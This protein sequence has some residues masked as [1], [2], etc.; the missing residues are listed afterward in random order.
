[1]PG[2][3]HVGCY[4]FP[5]YH[6]DPRNE[7]VHGKGWTEWEVVKR[8]CPRFAGHEQPR[9]PR[10]GYEDEAD[11]RVMARKI[12]AAADH[13]VDGFIFD[14][15]WYDDGPFLNR[16]LERGFLRAPNRERLRFSCMWANHDWTDIHPAGRRQPYTLLYPGRVTPATFR[17][18]TDHVIRRYFRHPSYWRIAGCPYFSV[19]DLGQLLR[20][21]G[22]L[23]GTRRALDDFRARTCRAGLPGLHLNAVL[24]GRP[25]LPGTAVP[26]DPVELVRTLG[27]DSVTS[28]VW[29]HHAALGKRRTIAYRRMQRAYRAYWLE[30][31]RRCPLPYFPNVT[32]GWDASPRTV[33]SERW[34]P[35]AGY[36]YTPIIAGATPAAFRQALREAKRGLAGAPVRILNINSWNEW[37][38]G[39][40]LEPDTR[41]GMAYL[42]AVR[43]VFG[44]RP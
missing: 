38:E 8:A 5:N 42:Q 11:P 19:Y 31:A 4:Y 26:A 30:T 10:W 12:A 43:E 7:R 34:D 28:Y 25:V 27:F 14:W 37:T 17:R 2:D 16:C 29:V 44:T 6:V 9:V 13:G 40:Y 23:A 15:Y 33:P 36:P 39:S 21:F 35:T 24:W 20:S 3:Y 22:T 41:H 1:M 32:V 18:M